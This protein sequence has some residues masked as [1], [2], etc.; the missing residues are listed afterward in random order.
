VGLFG[1]V[2]LQRAGDG[3]Q[4]T[5]GGIGERAALQ[6]DV[7]VDAEP[8]QCGDLFTA[9]PGHAPLAAGHR[10]PDR[11]RA[12]PRPARGEELLDLAAMVH[13]FHGKHTRG[14]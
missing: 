2:E 6:A 14:G 11:L 12:Y 5:V 7:V 10:Q 1:G 9:Q 8:G 3:V 4:D 13:A